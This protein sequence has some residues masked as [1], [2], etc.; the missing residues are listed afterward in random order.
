M[1]VRRYFDK[2]GCGYIKVDDMRRLL[3]NLGA[4]LPHRLVKDLASV[5][6][7]TS[8]GSRGR[9][10]RVY[11]REIADKMPAEGAEAVTSPQK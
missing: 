7:D 10:E 9:G 5:A 6:A 1:F 8:G 4:G 3:H 2:S 11:Y